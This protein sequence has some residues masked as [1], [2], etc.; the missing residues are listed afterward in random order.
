MSKLE[1]ILT[2]IRTSNI[3]TVSYKYLKKKFNNKLDQIIEFLKSEKYEVPSKDSITE[4][5]EQTEKLGAQFII[6]EASLPNNTFVPPILIIKGNKDLL[7]QSKVAAVGTREC[8]LIGSNFTKDIIQKISKRKIIIVSGLAK[9]IDTIV[10]MNSLKTGTIAV[11]PGDINT[12]Y[13]SYNN[14]LFQ[15]IGKSGLLITQQPLGT[16]IFNYHFPIRNNLIAAL[17]DYGLIMESSLKSGAL[18]TAKKFLLCRKKVYAVPGHP[19]D[20]KY[21]GNNY[22]IQ[23]GSTMLCSADDIQEDYICNDIIGDMSSHN[24]QYNEKTILN[25]L[26]YSVPVHIDRICEILDIPIEQVNHIIGKLLIEKKI[27]I[28]KEFSITRALDI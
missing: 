10:H 17:C 14:P 7:F 19:Y 12:A 15:S 3:G 13:P 2:I 21:S 26:T 16:K 24:C 28:N 20:Y 8:S 1:Q 22:L 4:E 18:D 27:I 11:L 23:Q 6:T 9:G 5:I 25:A